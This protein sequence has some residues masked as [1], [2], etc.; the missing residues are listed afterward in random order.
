MR[1]QV[2]TVPVLALAAAI[3][4][5]NAFPTVENLVRMMQTPNGV[6]KRCPYAEL[7]AGIETALEK[8]QLVNTNA[9]IDGMS[10]IIPCLKFRPLC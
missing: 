9:P 5:V 3:A 10:K 8:R 2:W 4:P 6:E 1:V 7:Q